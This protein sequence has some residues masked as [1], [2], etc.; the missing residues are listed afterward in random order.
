M[1]N[2]D[3]DQSV[4]D[5]LRTIPG[6]SDRWP[7]GKVPD[8]PEDWSAKSPLPNCRCSDRPL[9]GGMRKREDTYRIALPTD[10]EVREGLKALGIDVEK[11]RVRKVTIVIEAG[12]AVVATVERFIQVS[13]A[14]ALL[15]HLATNGGG[16][17]PMAT[18]T[19]KEY[20]ERVAENV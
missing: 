11:D 14:E 5:V 15:R 19:D 1:K 8:L 10:P 12:R 13:E 7:S 3:I 9:E 20:W 16:L 18:G 4:V 6:L 2:N 17:D